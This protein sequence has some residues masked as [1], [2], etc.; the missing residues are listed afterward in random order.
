MSYFTDSN[1]NFNSG[2]SFESS[3][4]DKIISNTVKLIEKF[5]GKTTTHFIDDQIP[6]G[7]FR[8]F[9]RTEWIGNREE[10]IIQIGVSSYNTKTS[11]ERAMAEVFYGSDYQYAK[12]WAHEESYKISNP[13]WRKQSY[14]INLEGYETLNQIRCQDAIG[15]QYVGTG[16]RITKEDIERQSQF[17]VDE[18][19]NPVQALKARQM[20]VDLSSSER[21][22]NET[23]DYYINKAKGLS[24]LGLSKLS[25]SFYNK[26]IAPWLLG[27][28]Q[29]IEPEQPEPETQDGD[30]DNDSDDTDQ[31]SQ[32]ESSADSDD[33]EESDSDDYDNSTSGSG[34]QDSDE[35]SEMESEAGLGDDGND[36]DEGDSMSQEGWDAKEELDS[37]DQTI[38]DQTK[39][40]TLS[41]DWDKGDNSISSS[42]T[43]GTEDWNNL[44]DEVSDEDQEDGQEEFNKVEEALY[45]T[46]YSDDTNA[47]N[48][49]EELKH[50]HV[51]KGYNPNGN[52]VPVNRM[53][54]KQLSKTFEKILQSSGEDNAP[55]GSELDI[56]AF[57]DS[58][59]DGRPEVFIQE[60]NTNEFQAI[61]GVDLSSSMDGNKI[62]TCLDICANLLES[63]K[64]I[65]KVKVKII[66]WTGNDSSCRIIE[67]TN[68]KEL[69]GFQASSLTPMAKGMIYCKNQLDR[70]QGTRKVM[71]FLTDGYPND[72]TDI[73]KV[74]QCVN[75]MRMNRYSVLGIGIGMNKADCDSDGMFPDMF[76]KGFIACPTVADVERVLRQDF[77]KEV[78]KFLRC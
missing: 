14:E 24:K 21:F 3:E 72:N 35:E 41:D 50:C 53:L 56:N 9:N 36:I 55:E 30:G 67:A 12:Q 2:L 28:L 69:Y 11:I 40:S 1:N 77:V 34:D 49:Q 15:K 19:L 8:I 32:S 31:D 45:D 22:D 27:N 4:K 38:S 58:R 47:I 76:G 75:E 48:V 60:E 10:D 5:T 16:E 23:M 43:N 74:K 78:S 13:D 57:I 51:N 20:G 63:I 42:Q 68:R 65:P 66:G 71:F 29:K 6:M 39:N 61:I 62:Q 18:I 52:E 70:M 54:V 37:I 26:V 25:K 46:S 33:G 73:P 17:P 59:I 44:E 64:S 7:E